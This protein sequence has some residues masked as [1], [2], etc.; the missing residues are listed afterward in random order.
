MLNLLLNLISSP[1]GFRKALTRLHPVFDVLGLTVLLFLGGHLSAQAQDSQLSG[2]RTPVETNTLIAQHQFLADGTYLYGESPQPE[3]IGKAYMVFEVK[4]GQITGAFYMPSSS[5]DCFSGVAQGNQLNLNITE[6]YSQQ[7]YSHSIG[8]NNS[9]VVAAV[10][11]QGADKNN[12]ALDG[13][14]RLSN[15]SQ[16]DQRILSQ[17]NTATKN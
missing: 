5:F 3:Q 12:L 17:C 13:F 6:S 14:H 10:G 16:N 1:G 9:S 11:S 15:L 4:Q 2:D 8:F 7:T